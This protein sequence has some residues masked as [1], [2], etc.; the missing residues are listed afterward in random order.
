MINQVRDDFFVL[1]NFYSAPVKYGGYTYRSNEAAFQAQKTLVETQRI[2]FIHLNPSDA[3]RKGR[4]VNLRPDWEEVKDNIMYE[5]VLA[6]FT[7]NEA[8]RK[9]L[10]STGEEELIE[11]NDWGDQYWGV[12][13][14]SGK[15][16]L[17]QILM[18][19]REE[20]KNL[21]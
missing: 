18:R 12:S 14:G 16:K 6:K 13:N 20:V 21:D 5:I 3:K 10:I 17:G 2:Q 4:H 1:S 11:G 15:N 9:R 8:L 7:Q 19:V